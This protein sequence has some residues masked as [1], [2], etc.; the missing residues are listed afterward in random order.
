M[1]DERFYT[2]GWIDAGF[3][4]WSG[5]GGWH[6]DESIAGE[7][8]NWGWSGNTKWGCGERNKIALKKALNLQEEAFEKNKDLIEIESS[9]NKHKKSII[10]SFSF[11]YWGP[12]SLGGKE[13]KS[14]SLESLL[15]A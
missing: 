11:M 13:D 6:G 10:E 3:E 14:S 1:W 4:A 9:G 15:Q 5:N 8:V 2:S 12:T 7:A